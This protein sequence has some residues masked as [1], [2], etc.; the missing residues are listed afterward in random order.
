MAIASVEQTYPVERDTVFLRYDDGTKKLGFDALR[1]GY[2]G[3]GFQNTRTVSRSLLDGRTL[4]SGGLAH[5]WRDWKG[6]FVCLADSEGMTRDAN[7][8]MIEL[9]TTTELIDALLADD[10]EVLSPED[11]DWWPC[12]F[13]GNPVP[14]MEYDPLGSY[15]VVV[16]R[17][18]QRE[19]VPRIA[20]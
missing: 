3:G 8:Q 16:G 7:G 10:L 2:E 13:V 11:N 19:Y 1:D 6:T 20:Y 17:L 9:G 4:V 15:M 18:I 5:G 14:R 12:T